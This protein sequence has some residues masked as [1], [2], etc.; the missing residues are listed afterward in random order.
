MK[1]CSEKGFAYERCAEEAEAVFRPEGVDEQGLTDDMCT[2]LL[3]LLSSYAAEMMPGSPTALLA[4]HSASGSGVESGMD[5]VA[6]EKNPQGRRR[7]ASPR[8]HRNFR[9]RSVCRTPQPYAAYNHEDCRRR[10]QCNI[11]NDLRRYHEE[12]STITRCCDTEGVCINL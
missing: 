12:V 2:D 4:R 11:R 1:Y 10:Q 7:N 3:W 9:R 5:G 6:V 8:R